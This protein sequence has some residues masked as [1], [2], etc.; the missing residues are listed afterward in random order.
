MKARLLGEIEVVTYGPNKLF[1]LTDRIASMVREEGD[2]T[3]ILCLNSMGSTGGLVLTYGDQSTVNEFE[4][5][6][7]D[8]VSTYGWRHPGNAY[9]HLRSSL[10]GTFLALPVIKGRLSIGDGEKIFFLENQMVVNRHRRIV[11]SLILD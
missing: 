2:V 3:G 1:D 10:I 9:A 4:R 11:V 8:L 5:S 6:L 7:W